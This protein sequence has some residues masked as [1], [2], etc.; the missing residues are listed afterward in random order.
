MGACF[1]CCVS[2]EGPDASAYRAGSSLRYVRLRQEATH[3]ADR[4]NL[5]SSTPNRPTPTHTA[6]RFPWSRAPGPQTEADRAARAAAAEAAAARQERFEMSP[7]GKAVKKSVQASKE[8][9]TNGRESTTI[10]DYIS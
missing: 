9:T 1:S 10:S 3:L 7:V 5:R 8:R 4:S 6:P 2:D